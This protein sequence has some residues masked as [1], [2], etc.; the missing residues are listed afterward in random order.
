MKHVSGSDSGTIYVSVRLDGE[1]DRHYFFTNFA[2]WYLTFGGLIRP[3]HFN[4]LLQSSE[5]RR[6]G[7]VE[8]ILRK[9]TDLE[10]LEAAM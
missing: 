10:V 3:C 9:I 5:S 2:T 8:T 4:R 6:E 1:G 7:S